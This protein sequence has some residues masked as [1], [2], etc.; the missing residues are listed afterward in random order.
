M[1]VIGSIRRNPEKPTFDSIVKVR[2]YTRSSVTTANSA[3]KRDAWL[4]GQ[5]SFFIDALTQLVHYCL[6]C[7]GQ[8]REFWVKWHHWCHSQ[9][10]SA[11]VN[12]HAQFVGHASASTFCNCRQQGSVLPFQAK[13]YAVNFLVFEHLSHPL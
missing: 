1:P 4:T 12:H 8:G 10:V 6:A 11:S 5:A 13:R 3:L 7:L 2:K 9:F